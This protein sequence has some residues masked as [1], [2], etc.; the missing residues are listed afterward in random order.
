M[1]APSSGIRQAVALELPKD[2][3]TLEE[4]AVAEI[5]NVIR[6]S[7]QLII[8]VDGLAT[9]KK[10]SSEVKQLI[11]FMEFPYFVIAYGKGTVSEKSHTF[12]GMCAG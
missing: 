2:D 10:V 8:I 7:K 9:M 1:S 5:R 3:A 12:S 6:G 4:K 11:A